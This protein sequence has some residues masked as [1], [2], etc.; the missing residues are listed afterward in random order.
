[1]PRPVLGPERL[2]ENLTLHIR[3]STTAVPRKHLGAGL[4]P[5]AGGPCGQW[6]PQRVVPAQDGPC[7]GWSPRPVVPAQDGPRGGW[8]PRWV[9]PAVGGPCGGWSLRRLVPEAGWTI[10]WGSR[11]DPGEARA[12]DELGMQRVPGRVAGAPPL[13]RCGMLSRSQGLH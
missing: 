4:V 9:V 2:R 3:P 1:M 6:S 8:S 12:G 11:A 7:S 10:L 13:T 5:A